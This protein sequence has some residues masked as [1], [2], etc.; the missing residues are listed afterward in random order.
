MTGENGQAAFSS[1]DLLA[2]G[3]GG[4][5]KW[6]TFAYTGRIPLKDVAPGRYLLTIE[7]HDRGAKP[8]QAVVA[9]TAV[10]IS[11]STR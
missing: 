7:S 3:S 1:S 5:P 8:G 6:T 11:P 10:V 9:Q 4:A 2:N